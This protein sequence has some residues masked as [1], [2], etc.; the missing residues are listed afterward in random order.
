L[1]ASTTR[2]MKQNTEPDVQSP[3]APVATVVPRP[4]G[5]RIF[6][7]FAALA[8]VVAAALLNPSQDRHF[9]EIDQIIQ[10]RQL[11]IGDGQS[12]V[13]LL[14]SY[15]NYFVFSTVTFGGN[16]LMDDSRVLSYGFFGTVKTTGNIKPVM[17]TIYEWEQ[18]QKGK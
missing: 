5:Q 10:R 16:K 15:N 4:K 2:S 13:H 8:I 1:F 3:A 6:V 12:A 18:T 17:V 9:E 11:S 14:A 7:A